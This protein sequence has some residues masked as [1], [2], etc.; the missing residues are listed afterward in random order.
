MRMVT[1]CMPSVQNDVAQSLSE[2][3]ALRRGLTNRASTRQRDQRSHGIGASRIQTIPV[4]SP[5]DA[6]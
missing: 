1:T 3:M 6:L 2:H 4:R 5:P